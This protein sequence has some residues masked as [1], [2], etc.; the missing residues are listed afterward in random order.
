METRRSTRLS[1]KENAKSGDAFKT[2]KQIADAER[3]GSASPVPAKKSKSSYFDPDFSEQSDDSDSL[4]QKKRPKG[5]TNSKPTRKSKQRYESEGDGSSDEFVQKPKSFTEILQ[6][7]SELKLSS[8]ESDSCEESPPK[9]IKK[10]DGSPAKKKPS[11]VKPLESDSSS[12]VFI[13]PISTELKSDS[14]CK[15]E[16]LDDKEE[17]MNSQAEYFDFTALVNKVK[18]CNEDSQVEQE[19]ETETEPEPEKEVK[20]KLLQKSKK[21]AKV[22]PK[23]EEKTDLE[24]FELLAMGEDTDLSAKDIKESVTKS[25]EEKYEIPNQVEVLLDAPILKKKK[26]NDLEMTLR[27]RLNFIRRENQVYIHKV[28]I[29]CWIAHGMHVNSVLNSPDLL[30]LALSLL[31]SDKCYPSKRMDMNYLG[32]LIEWFAKKIKVKKEPLENKKIKLMISL[33]TQFQKLEA[34]NKTDLCFMF[35][36]VIRALGIKCRLII[37]LNVVPLKPTSD[38][39]LSITVK[40]NDNQPTSTKKMLEKENS[41]KEKSSAKKELKISKKDD[42]ESEKSKTPARSRSEKESKNDSKEKSSRSQS[43]KSKST[44]TERSSRSKSKNVRASDRSRSQPEKSKESN[45]RSPC[46]KSEKSKES[47]DRSSRSKS[48]KSGETN[49]R[50]SRSQSE[51]SKEKDAAKGEPTQRSNSRGKKSEAEKSQEPRRSTR[52]KSTDAKKQSEYFQDEKTSRR[53]ERV[54]SKS[55]YFSK[56]NESKSVKGKES[57]KKKSKKSSKDEKESTKETGYLVE[58]MSSSDDSD[59]TDDTFVRVKKKKID[60]RVLSSEEDV[61]VEEKLDV[62]CKQN[63]MNYWLEVYLEAEEQWICVDIAKKSY[64]C[65]QPLYVSIFKSESI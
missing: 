13:K 49:N 29:L 14:V 30:S 3:D 32:Q 11:S 28:H 16:P 35:I 10:S 31:P 38:Q 53:S 58:E 56:D 39:L 21:A 9:R 57:C 34:E 18:A 25:S 45:D 42:K 65:I 17:Q 20:P 6:S 22:K 55:N 2:R 24:V 36:C 4:P 7:K 59:D 52:S 54:S 23:N 37:N 64:H 60:R 41:V 61:N 47:N 46:S 27:R 5:K 63:K 12:D 50:S 44:V 1:L 33:Q 43:E 19:V 26:T 15:N 8:D 40:K 62:K 48:E 51:K